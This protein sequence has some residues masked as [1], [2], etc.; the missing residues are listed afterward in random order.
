MFVVREFRV[1]SY[2]WWR[3]SVIVEGCAIH[4]VLHALYNGCFEAFLVPDQLVSL[5]EGVNL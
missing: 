1:L 5:K 3:H 4:M 2:G